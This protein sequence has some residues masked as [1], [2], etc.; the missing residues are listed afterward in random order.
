[1]SGSSLSRKSKAVFSSLTAWQTD[2]ALASVRDWAA[3][4][5]LADAERQQ[6]Q[7]LWVDVGIVHLLFRLVGLLRHARGKRQ[8]SQ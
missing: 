5:K 7:R 6:W 4:A 1:L 2:A 8:T 3:L